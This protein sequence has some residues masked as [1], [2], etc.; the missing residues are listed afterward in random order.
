MQTIGGAFGFACF[1]A[2]LIYD[3]KNDY[4]MAVRFLRMC[5]ICTFFVYFAMLNSTTLFHPNETR[6]MVAKTG[7]SLFLAGIFGAYCLVQTSYY[8][9][10]TKS[11][12]VINSINNEKLNTLGKQTITF[13][14]TPVFENPEDIIS[15]GTH[16]VI[17]LSGM[18]MNETRLRLDHRVT[19]SGA[20][21][22][23]FSSAEC[24]ELHNET[25]PGPAFDIVKYVQCLPF[26]YNMQDCSTSYKM[27]GS[28]TL[29]NNTDD[30]IEDVR[31]IFQQL[32][33]LDQIA[34]VQMVDKGPSEVGMS[35]TISSSYFFNGTEYDN[36]TEYFRNG[37]DFLF[38]VESCRPHSD[39]I[40]DSCDGKT[41]PCYNFVND[42]TLLDSCLKILKFECTKSEFSG[43]IVVEQET[44]GDDFDITILEDALRE[45]LEIPLAEMDLEMDEIY[46][47]AVFKFTS[48]D[49]LGIQN[50]GKKCTDEDALTK[51]NAHVDV[52]E[53]AYV[54]A[55]YCTLNILSGNIGYEHTDNWEEDRITVYDKIN[56]DFGL[57]EMDAN[58]YQLERHHDGLANYS[59]YIP[60]DLGD[61]LDTC[62][63]MAAR[64]GTDM[65]LP[66]TSITCFENGVNMLGDRR[67]LFASA[68]MGIACQFSDFDTVYGTFYK[69]PQEQCNPQR[70]YIDGQRDF[71]C[72]RSTCGYCEAGTADISYEDYLDIVFGSTTTPEPMDCSASGQAYSISFFSG[73]FPM[74]M[75]I[76]ILNAPSNCQI[77]QDAPWVKDSYY[78]ATCCLEDGDYIAACHDEHG[79]GWG[80]A[81]LFINDRMLCEVPALEHWQNVSFT[82]PDFFTSRQNFDTTEDPSSKDD[83]G[84]T[85]YTFG[86]DTI[87]MT[88]GEYKKL[89][90]GTCSSRDFGLIQNPTECESVFAKVEETVRNLFP[91]ADF[92]IRFEEVQVGSIPGG[93]TYDHNDLEM[94]ITE[95]GG[96]PHHYGLS[97]R[98]LR[99]RRLPGGKDDDPTTTAEGD[100]WESQTTPSADDE[101]GGGRDDAD[102]GPSPTACTLPQLTPDG[103]D[104]DPTAI[105]TGCTSADCTNPIFTGVS[106][107]SGYSGIVSTTACSSS[108][109]TVTLTGCTTTICTLPPDA[110]MGYSFDGAAVISGCDSADCSNVV[111]TGVSCD[112]GYSGIVTTLGCTPS[113]SDVTLSGCS[114]GGD[115]DNDNDG[116]NGNSGPSG[117]DGATGDGAGASNSGET[118]DSDIDGGYDGDGQQDSGNVDC[119]GVPDG[120][121]VEDECGVCQGDG[122]SCADCEGVPNG[123]AV[124]DACG[125]CQGEGSSCADCEGAPNG[126]AVED[127]CGV[128]QGDGSSCDDDKDDGG[129]EPNSGNADSGSPGEDQSGPSGGGQ[130]GGDTSGDEGGDGGGETAGSPSSN[131]DYGQGG[132][133]S[134]DENS[135]DSHSG[136][137]GE[138]GQPNDSSNDGGNDQPSGESPSGD[139]DAT[140][141]DDF[142][143]GGD[144]YGD[145]GN[146][147]NDQS[148]SPGGGQ[149]GGDT[150]GDDGGD[151]G[152]ESP[153]GDNDAT[154]GDDF[155]DGGDAYGDDG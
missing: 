6:S 70:C 110:P 68:G 106:C 50:A 48:Y 118:G 64:S 105:I 2:A 93:C 25:Y 150:S 94:V 4:D 5:A 29:R 37:T 62:L 133:A 102:S 136:S 113:T 141:G 40:I 121:A 42:P 15:I 36:S 65:I 148:G 145:D 92:S 97:G 51:F 120:P 35:Y 39:D 26:T 17:A 7:L 10:A 80:N 131:N 116:D 49:S 155:D 54:R 130:A 86:D 96:D 124:V 114:S 142:D 77:N 79:Y 107:A 53:I 144:A 91:D 47:T 24:D 143:D 84:D 139:N 3:G 88:E 111:F 122:T 132:D 1:I 147:G 75:S 52:S 89:E 82:L 27:E 123:L 30:L 41:A 134:G 85:G 98:R 117:G 149:A 43:M 71:Y 33:I 18:S 146:S 34:Q 154:S 138:D 8:N 23:S 129:G 16:P 151:G 127:A 28:L 22:V 99:R 137:P 32:F 95:A 76:D 152:G 135:G 21:S 55:V 83:S 19:A 73:P 60:D 11:P 14:L 69:C 58:F 66:L 45:T 90:W 72:C 128:C 100:D 12:V 153:S 101:D 13:M 20:G 57:W 140:S 59:I 44:E 9:T 109:S 74:R 56:E 81:E 87:S 38:Y 67:R 125:V 63:Q 103:Y 61:T 119:D 115:D 46:T 31:K 112:T 78:E 126:L 104:I 108:A